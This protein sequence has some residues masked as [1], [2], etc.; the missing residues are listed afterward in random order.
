MMTL[1][2][3]LHAPRCCRRGCLLRPFQNGGKVLPCYERIT[4]APLEA[5]GGLFSTKHAVCP[6]SG[7]VSYIWALSVFLTGGYNGRYK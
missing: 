4:L 3:L 6:R 5:S 2:D 7:M 1:R